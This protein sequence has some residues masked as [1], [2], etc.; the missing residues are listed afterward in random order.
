M[1]ERI[2]ILLSV[3]LV[4][5]IVFAGM[6][7]M[8]IKSVRYD[9]DLYVEGAKRVGFNV[10]TDAVHFGIVPP[11]AS[12]E[13]IVVVETD[14]E[15]RVRVKSSGELAKWVSV[16]DNDFVLGRDELKEISITTSVPED[17][18]IGKYE[19]EITISL[20]RT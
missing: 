20:Y 9:M 11:G 2:A 3:L 18:E 19:G 14:V 16:S 12:G 8:P 17:A 10:D 7:M 1:E 6:Q 5:V 13:R 15:A 4:L